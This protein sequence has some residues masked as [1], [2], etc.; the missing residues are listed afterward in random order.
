MIIF[1]D[2]NYMPCSAPIDD[3]SS[4]IWSLKYYEDGTFSAVVSKKYLSNALSA[5]YVYN[6]DADD[7]MRIDYIKY[8]SSAKVLTVSGRALTSLL[9]D[10]II[11]NVSTSAS[12]TE[13]IVRSLIT[14]N[15]LTSTR[16]IN[17][18]SMAA[19]HNYAYIS[20]A[21]S[22]AQGKKLS[23]K[24]RE[25]LKP[26]EL[27]YQIKY[28]YIDDTLIFDIVQGIDRT[29]E[30]TTNAFAIFSTSFENLG[31]IEYVKNKRDYAN[32]VMRGTN[33][34]LDQSNGG[35]RKEI[36]V[37]GDVSTSET[38]ADK[39]IIESVTGEVYDAVN[40]VYGVNYNL[41][42]KCDIYDADS[43]VSMAARIT[44]V[45]MV[46]NDGKRRVIPRFGE[47]SVS[48]RKQIKNIV[49]G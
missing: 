44:Q 23:E 32:V 15:A 12:N 39:N 48:I 9:D 30:Q 33:T 29:Q 1:L 6:T 26:H 20:E 41:G 2:I 36:F 45:D 34:A 18:L 42:D 31:N 13:N 4:L 8:S 46:Y 10:R 38:L 28:N 47:G 43:G 25:M 37:S 21:D 22:A 5:E 40:L 7:T 19:A 24:I 35:T 3:Y 27:S 16:T 49:K 11:V 17:K 14:T